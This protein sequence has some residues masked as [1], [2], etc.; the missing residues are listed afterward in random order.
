MFLLWCY[1]LVFFVC[2]LALRVC[3]FVSRTPVGRAH[4]AVARWLIS[5]IFFPGD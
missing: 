5:E 2:W 3:L 4:I 1:L